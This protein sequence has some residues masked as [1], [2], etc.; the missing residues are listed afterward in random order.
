MGE[1]VFI[2]KLRFMTCIKDSKHD[3]YKYVYRTIH[4]KWKWHAQVG[5]KQKDFECDR[6]AAK[7]VDL[8]LIEN[9]K[10]PV[11]ILIRK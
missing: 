2:L 1:E 9:G 5:R 7:W 6:E 8:R 4:N 10:E 11:N 3:K